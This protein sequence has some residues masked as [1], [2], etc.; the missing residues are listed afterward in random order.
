MTN[1]DLLTPMSIWDYLLLGVI[2]LIVGLLISLFVSNVLKGIE[3]RMEGIENGQI[4]HKYKLPIYIL[5]LIIAVLLPLWYSQPEHKL[6]NILKHVM[7]VLFIFNISWMV[8]QF[9][10]ISIS[11]VLSKYDMEHK[12]NLKAR[13][14]YTQFRIIER[15][16]VTIIIIISVGIALMTIDGIKRVGISLFASAGV[17][18]I[19]IGFSAQKMLA[20]VLAGFQIAITQPIRLDDVLIVEGEWGRVEEITLTYVVIRIWDKRRLVVPTSYFIENPFQNWT[21][22]S[23][24]LL[25]T[26]FIYTDYT[27]PIDKLRK[28]TTRIVEGTDLWDKKVNIIQVTNATEKTMELRLLLSAVDSPTLWDLRVLVR[29]KIIEFLQKNYPEHLPKS[30][31]VIDG[32]KDKKPENL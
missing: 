2:A 30:R 31:V 25:G 24:D 18:G 19:V 32:E 23:S 13:K 26:V 11:V 29:E 28:E 1:I 14:V 20:S 10:R 15:I 17:A 6:L 3:K 8:V 5:V 16:I 12:D 21:R 4:R 7:I 9:I 22:V 27:V